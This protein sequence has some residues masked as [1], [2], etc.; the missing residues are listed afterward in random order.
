MFIKVTFLFGR[1]TY[2]VLIFEA[3]G[4][5]PLAINFFGRTA[6]VIMRIILAAIEEN[7]KRIT[8]NLVGRYIGTLICFVR[9]FI[10]A[11]RRKRTKPKPA[12][13]N[14]DS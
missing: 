7:D 14:S 11:S 12:D 5:F 6:K 9:N 10:P 2:F 8:M 1:A 4:I 13:K 3:T